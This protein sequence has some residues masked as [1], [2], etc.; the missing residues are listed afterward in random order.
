[1]Q[2]QINKYRLHYKA[3]GGKTYWVHSH[4]SQKTADYVWRAFYAF[5][6]HGGKEIHFSKWS[7][8]TT[9][10]SK[11]AASGIIYRGNGIIEINKMVIKA[12]M[13]KKDRYGYQQ[14]ALKRP[15][16]FCSLS[17]KWYANG[18]KYFLQLT[19]DGKPPMK[20]DPNTGELIHALGS[21]R[22]G[23][24]IG[25]QTLASCGES[26]VQLI[27]L[28]DRVK[29]IDSQLRRI[30]RAMD[31]SRRATNPQMF[32][33]AGCAIPINKL[34]KDCLTERNTRCW[35]KSKRYLQLEGIRRELYRRQAE[36]RAQ[37][38]HELANQLLA[39]G[40]VHF[41]EE[42]RFR[43]LAK[44]SKEDKVNAKGK[45]RRKKRF[46]KS[47]SNKAPASFVTILKQ[48][49]ENAGG[50]CIKVDTIHMKASQF[51]HLTETYTKKNLSQR[52]NIM[53]DGKHI[54]RDLYSAFLIMNVNDTYNAADVQRCNNTY[55]RFIQLHD[56]E[57]ERLKTIFMPSSAGIQRTV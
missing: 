51:N 7:E 1:M 23:H 6:Y 25:T 35:Y 45:H 56:A 3:K 36:L 5:F 42:M 9:I 34:P 53:P 55:P 10:S 4:I 43:A 8:F 57:I 33:A 2:K 24:D 31:R 16:R 41:I 44:K 19:L 27:E 12:V 50:A 46:G 48:K 40:D 49:V 30:N 37:Q 21:G 26:N 39:F 18:W 14:E 13:D 11:S 28:A 15:V 47:I 17:R 54:Q 52:W 29:P 22:V 38:H 20:I 32:D